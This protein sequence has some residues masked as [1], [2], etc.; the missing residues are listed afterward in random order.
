MMHYIRY[1]HGSAMWSPS[2]EATHR[3]SFGAHSRK[4]RQSR[5]LSGST[6]T[7]HIVADAAYIRSVDIPLCK[8]I[9][10]ASLE[11]VC[12]NQAGRQRIDARTACFRKVRQAP[13]PT[14]ISVATAGF[15]TATR[16]VPSQYLAGST[17]LGAHFW[18]RR[19]LSF[20]DP[21]N[22]REAFSGVNPRPTFLCVS[23]L[24]QEA[25]FGDLLHSVR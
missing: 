17:C 6:V 21:H 16:L 19:N 11:N 2:T 22:G 1:L 9:G 23:V 7:T 12:A 4:N 8:M 14:S 10:I 24:E 3:I 25:F 18:Y 15:N 20:V 13:A 5:R